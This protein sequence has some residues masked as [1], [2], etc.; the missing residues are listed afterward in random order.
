MS[1]ASPKHAWWV[2]ARREVMVKLTDKAFWISTAVVIAL[3]AAA[4]G[5]SFIFASES[6]SMTVGVNDDD[7]LQV[8]ALAEQASS[9]DINVIRMQASEFDDAVEEGTIDAGLVHGDDGWEMVVDSIETSTGDLQQAIVTFMTQRNAEALGVDVSA[10]QE[11]A[12]VQIRLAGEQLAEDAVVA[13]VAGMVFAVLFLMSALTYGLQIAQS[14]VEEKESRIVE[15]LSSAIPARQLLVG[16]A[17]GNTIMAMGQLLIYV[18]IAMVGLSFTEFSAFLPMLAPAVG[19]F[20]LFFLVGFAALSTLWA[21]TG[22]MATRVQDV[23]NTTT[24]LMMILMLAYF[25]GFFAR[26][27]AAQVLSYIPIVS[28][29]TMPQRLLMG[30]AGWLD[31]IIALA[32]CVLF[33]AAAIKVG[34]IIYRRGLLKT[35]GILKLREAFARD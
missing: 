4:F 34:E 21:A 32:L 12:E 8:V 25:A 7:G 16:K 29:T 23:G 9:Q 18:V 26:G 20:I 5:F 3:M 22:A 6:S 24:P 19:W 30:E 35:S 2:V 14:V 27:D 10:L 33:M 28:T 13:L 1:Y 31:A 17:L 11:G 15:I